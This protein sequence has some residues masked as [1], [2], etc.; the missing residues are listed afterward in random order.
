MLERFWRSDKPKEPEAL[1]LNSLRVE[2]G[3]FALSEGE[4]LHWMVKEPLEKKLKEYEQRLDASE[5]Q[6][7]YTT[8]MQ[9]PENE[10]NVAKKEMLTNLYKHEMLQTF[11]E[12][13]A[14]RLQDFHSRHEN[15]DMYDAGAMEQAYNDVYFR[16]NKTINQPS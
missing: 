13:G 14:V 10:I 3:G 11:L 8:G 5:S 16:I 15:D 9:R 1:S 6:M 7:S 4:E 12:T 2:D